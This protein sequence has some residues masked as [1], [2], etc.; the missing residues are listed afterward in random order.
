MENDIS[1]GSHQII[2]H[3]WMLQS[4]C[5]ESPD[6]RELLKNGLSGDVQ[7]I[8]LGACHLGDSTVG[9]EF[10]KL[11]GDSYYIFPN[12]VIISKLT[13]IFQFNIL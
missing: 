13:L 12:I 11:K 10:H 3:D 4:K 5:D 2:C 6:A 1:V 9:P 8:I 7:W